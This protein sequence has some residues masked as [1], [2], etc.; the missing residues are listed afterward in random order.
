MI[1][2]LLE[3]RFR[4][5]ANCEVMVFDHILSVQVVSCDFNGDSHSSTFDAGAGIALNDHFVKLVSWYVLP[6]GGG[7]ALRG[8]GLALLLP[9]CCS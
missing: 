6:W 8:K 5:L 1:P 2:A 4:L 7:K 9:V 3:F